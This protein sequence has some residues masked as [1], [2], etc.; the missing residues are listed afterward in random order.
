MAL[1][2]AGADLLLPQLPEAGEETDR[3]ESLEA[4]SEGGLSPLRSPLSDISADSGVLAEDDF[5]TSLFGEDFS[6]LSSATDIYMSTQP[7]GDPL[8]PVD[9]NQVPPESLLTAVSEEEAVSQSRSAFGRP[10]RSRR[11]AIQAMASSEKSDRN[12]RNAEM[13]RQHRQKKKQYVETLEQDRIALKTENVLLKTRTD[14]LRTHVRKLENEVQYLKSVLANQSTLAA[15]IHSIPNTPGVRLSTSFEA[16]R[17]R[18]RDDSDSETPA[19]FKRSRKDQA[20]SMTGGVCLHVSKD[21][22]SL[23]F[24]PTCSKQAARS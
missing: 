12:Q 5:L 1:S 17:K 4:L 2:P 14:E 11:A 15:L 8:A 24:C 10:V 7:L 18:P 3:T 21:V 9:V 23:E 13:A 20:P 19:R 16:T 22:V 6:M